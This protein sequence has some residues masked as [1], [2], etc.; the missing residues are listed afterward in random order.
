MPA[1]GVEEYLAGFPPGPQEVLRGL[2]AAILRG[3]P[4]TPES[5]R[6][7]MAAFHLGGR[8][9]L[10]LGGWARHAGLYPVPR[11]DDLEDRVAPYRTSGSTV[12]LPYTVAV[13]YDLV[14]QLAAHIAS[15]EQ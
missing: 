6:Y 13:P 10:H 7:R 5:I 3:A 12:A 9:W 1:A 8:T 15:P 2:R 14:E 4:G 11:F